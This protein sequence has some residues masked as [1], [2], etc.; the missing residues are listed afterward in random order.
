MIVRGATVV[1]AN[2]DTTLL[3]VGG[4]DTDREADVTVTV[5]NNGTV[6][7]TFRLAVRPLG[8]AVAAKDYLAYD[9]TIPNGEQ[10]IYNLALLGTDIVL[11]RASHADVV[12]HYDGREAERTVI[13]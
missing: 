3:T 8:A 2:T 6:P 13:V 11:V 5:S 1:V 10:Y 9:A 7:R 4:T 12:F